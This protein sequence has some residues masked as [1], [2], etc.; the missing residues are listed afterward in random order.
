VQPLS[1]V[2]HIGRELGLV[3][4]QLMAKGVSVVGINSNDWAAYPDDAPELMS[5]TAHRFGGE[6]PYL[7]D[8]DQSMALSHQAACTPD[9]L[10]FNGS[11]SLVYRG[12]F[13]ESRPGAD[14]PV[15]GAELHHAA[16]AVVRGDPVPADQRPSVGCSIKWRPGNALEWFS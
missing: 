16:K 5:A 13:D 14:V 3:T 8:A 2:I 9:F 7:V 12:Q 1:I 10:V 11:H 6:F 15:T 4:Q